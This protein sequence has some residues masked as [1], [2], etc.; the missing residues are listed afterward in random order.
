MNR[1]VEI[2]I[3]LDQEQFE[4]VFAYAKTV[5]GKTT[6]QTNYYYD[7]A[8][9]LF[10]NRGMTLR[11]REKAGKFV[12][13]LKKKVAKWKNG[14]ASEE[15]HFGVETP[16]KELVFSSVPQL[17]ERLE[18]EDMP[19]PQSVFCS[20]SLVTERTRFTIPVFDLSVELDRSLYLGQT[21]FELECELS[22][23]SQEEAVLKFLDAKFGIRPLKKVCGKY[24]RFLHRL[25][26]NDGK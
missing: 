23:R 25:H 1:E 12:L 2:K 4:R 3:L 26:E 19:L 15:Y 16:P 21:D 24:H 18:K 5:G 7:T 9:E 17:L 20:G 22:E 8:D 13:T 10:C 11:I 6:V 14:A